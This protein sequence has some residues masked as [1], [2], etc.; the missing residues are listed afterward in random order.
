MTP[1]ASIMVV[2]GPPLKVDPTL[3]LSLDLLFLRLFSISIP[4]FL[5]D[6]KIYGQSFDCGIA[7]PSLVDALSFC[8]RS[9]Q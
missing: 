3:G 8:W 5:S 6:R 7:T 1:K 4:A 2:L 9:A